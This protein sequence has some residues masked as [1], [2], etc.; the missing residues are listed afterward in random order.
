[1]I[2]VWVNQMI[3]QSTCG[4]IGDSANVLERLAVETVSHKRFA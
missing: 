4:L 3:R 1:M 2:S